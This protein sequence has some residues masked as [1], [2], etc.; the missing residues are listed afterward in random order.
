MALLLCQVL[1]K[2]HTNTHGYPK[3]EAFFSDN[4]MA[5]ACAALP[6]KKSAAQHLQTKLYTNLRHWT[7]IFP[8]CLYW[9]P[10][11]VG[12]PEN[13]KVDKLEKLAAESQITSHHTID[14]MSLSKLRQASKEALR[15]DP[16][17]REEISRIKYKT[18]PKLI[19]KAL[20]PLEKGP[21]ATIHQ[22]QTNHVPSNDYLNQIKRHKSPNSQHC[23]AKK[24][25]TT[26]YS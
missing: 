7:N 20:D 16:L 9:C 22:L 17:T 5:L 10:G 21:A 3:A 19:N 26:T 6:K 13:K 15:D 18:P 25:H 24:H 8:V 2:E 1:L 4:Q 11:H 14:T 12:I 23:N